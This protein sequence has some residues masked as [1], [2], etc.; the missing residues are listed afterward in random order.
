[1]SVTVRV[2]VTVRMSVTVSVSVTVSMSVTVMERLMS[3]SYNLYKQALYCIP[4][5]DPL[6]LKVGICSR[7]AVHPSLNSQRLLFDQMQPRKK[8]E[9]KAAL[10]ADS[11]A[12]A[13]LSA[14][15]Q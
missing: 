12:A 4:P 6:D 7:H 14:A 8:V 9:H 10:V 2:S 13:M 5:D 11:T 1:M 15:K 3:I